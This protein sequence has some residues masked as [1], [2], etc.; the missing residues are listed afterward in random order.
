MKNEIKALLQDLVA[1]E[2]VTPFDHGCQGY[3]MDYLKALGFTCQALNNPPVSNF[4]ATIGQGEPFLIF[5]GHTDVVPAGELSK[6]QTEPFKLSEQ[7]NILSGRGVADMK[8]SL[9]AMLVAIKYFLKR[10]SSFSG[11]VG[12]LITSGEE[13][14]HFHLGT[15]Y[16]MEK[17]SEQGQVPDYCILGEPSSTEHVGDVMKIG[18]RGSLTAKVTLHGIQG[19]VAYPH[20]AQNPIHILSPALLELS[21]KEWDKGNS[22]FPPTSMQITHIHSGGDAPNV[23]PGELF[24]QFNFRYSTE[25]TADDIKE[26]VL[27]CF[28]KYDLN[29]EIHWRLNGE[30]FITDH[31]LLLEATE[32]AIHSVIGRKPERSTSGGTSD[33]RFI[34]P[35]GTELI[36]LGPVNKTIHQVNECVSLNDLEQLCEIYRLICESLL[37]S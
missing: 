8:G 7:S 21:S 17:L 25:R 33:G 26:E 4:I 12:F 16:V 23:I 18:R 13:G 15:P 20:L 37:S 32:K 1:F 28:K 29:P 9:A 14:D 11:K 24:L 2:S 34:A 35:Y 6:W 27:E 36:E 5:A 22:S 10:N 3:M 31:G 30:P 19:H